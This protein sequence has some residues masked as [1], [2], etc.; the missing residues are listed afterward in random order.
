MMIQ[1]LAI[2]QV[3]VHRRVPKTSQNHF[4]YEKCALHDFLFALLLQE[5]AVREEIPN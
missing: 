5:Q 1:N 4:S 2:R 3:R